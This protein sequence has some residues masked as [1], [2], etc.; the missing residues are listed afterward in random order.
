MEFLC[1]AN[2]ISAHKDRNFAHTME[3]QL[4]CDV[5]HELGPKFYAA[6]SNSKFRTKSHGIL[7][8]LTEKK[9]PRGF[10]VLQ[11]FQS[12]HCHGNQ[13]LTQWQWGQTGV[14]NTICISLNAY[15]N[16]HATLTL[17]GSWTSRSIFRRIRGH[18]R[19]SQS[20]GNSCLMTRS[21]GGIVIG[22]NGSLWSVF[23][24]RW[25][26]C[27]WIAVL[28]GS[29]MSIVW[30]SEKITFKCTCSP[31]DNYMYIISIHIRSAQCCTAVALFIY[32]SLYFTTLY[33]K[34]TLIRTQNFVPKCNF[35][36][37]K[38][39]LYFKTTCHM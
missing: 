7:W 23:I 2:R 14:F 36:W 3:T 15:C 20:R 22:W 9:R 28:C 37:Y 12:M 33:F 13:V 21:G 16:A 29:M 6:V 19:W 24:L 10:T 4:F 17:E 1:L 35:V 27:P 18:P 26:L 31:T 5:T 34:I 38:L 32:W 11:T 25:Q 8:G 30:K 39:N